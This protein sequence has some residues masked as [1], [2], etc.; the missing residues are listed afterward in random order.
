MAN[1]WSGDVSHVLA[2]K[3]CGADRVEQGPVDISSQG[4]KGEH[5]ITSPAGIATQHL[6]GGTDNHIEICFARPYEVF[7]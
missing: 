1:A 3:N 4:Q 6:G 2:S 7:R 5:S